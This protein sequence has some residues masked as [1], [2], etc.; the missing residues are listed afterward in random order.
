MEYLTITHP[1]W[2]PMWDQLAADRLNGG[3]PVCALAGQGW[4]YMGSTQD[5]HHFRHPCHPVTEKAEYFY[6]ERAGVAFSW[7]C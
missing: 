4:E 5:H 2:Q 7:A 6:L 3:D 1:E